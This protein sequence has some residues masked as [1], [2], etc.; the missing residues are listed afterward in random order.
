MGSIRR[1]KTITAI[2]V[3][4]LVQCTLIKSHS[5]ARG[6]IQIHT[7]TTDRSGRAGELLL[8]GSGSD[9][10][11]RR[12]GRGS[13]SNSSCAGSWSSWSTCRG[14]TQNRTYTVTTKPRN[15]GTAC[16][17]SPESQ[18][19]KC[20]AQGFKFHTK[21]QNCHNCPNGNGGGGSFLEILS[22]SKQSVWEYYGGNIV[23]NKQNYG[24]KCKATMFKHVFEHSGFKGHL[25][26]SA[27]WNCGGT[28]PANPFCVC[29]EWFSQN[30]KE[31]MVFTAKKDGREDRLTFTNEQ[32]VKYSID[33][34][35]KD[36]CSKSKLG[37]RRIL[38]GS[39]AMFHEVPSILN[40][41]KQCV[42]RRRRLLHRG[43]G[44]C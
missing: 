16:P 23:P 26:C 4:V 24:I 14:G 2:I 21:G 19:C 9:G 28:N 8:S 13:G 25:P 43:R 30:L 22:S 15:G 31:D 37:K 10:H 27:E 18:S 34:T 20:L 12:R 6:S 7:A 5:V 17:K 40:R 1:V 32:E 44:G 41:D 35:K 39:N 33:S 3:I 36:L 11:D 29:L 38:L 42:S